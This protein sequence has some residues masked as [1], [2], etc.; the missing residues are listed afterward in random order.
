MPQHFDALIIG[1]G[2]AGGVCARM[3]RAAGLTVAMAESGPFGGA[4]ALRGCE[5]KKVLAETTHAVARVRDMAT[6]AASEAIFPSTGP[7]WPPAKGIMSSASPPWPNTPTK[8][9]A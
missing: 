8:K 5:P 6:R 1:S 3:L 7:P 2:A 9:T 4:C